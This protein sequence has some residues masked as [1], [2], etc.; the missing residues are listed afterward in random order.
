MHETEFLTNVAV[1]LLAALAGGFLAR[2]MRL[3]VLIGY[4]VAGVFIGPH[5]PGVIASPEIV[6]A[7][8]KLGVA[9]LMFTV[10][11]HFSLDRL[12]SVRRVALLGGGLQIAGTV[13]LG[14]L[15]GLALG[16]GLYGGLF[17]GCAISLSSTAV[18]T[19]L[20]EERGEEGSPHGEA[21]LAVLIAQD[22][23][24]VVMTPLLPALSDVARHGVSAAKALAGAA[25]SGGLLLALILLLAMRVVPALMKRMTGM[26]S[27]ELFLLTGLG[28]CLAAA[29]AAE[30]AGIGL[31]LG[32]FLA[33]LVISET[34]YAHELFAQIRPLRDVF[35]ALFFVS[36]G[37]LLNP[38]FLR[39]HWVAVAAVV[40]AI[41]FGKAL[42]SALAVRAAGR[43]G[44]TAVIA[45]LGLAQIGEFS[46]VLASIGSAR[47]L[48]PGEISGVI[49]SAALISLVLAPFLF[50]AAFPLAA[51]LDAAPALSRFR[52]P[53]VG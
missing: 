29:L 13:A 30:R 36:I 26:G 19:K 12:K 22:L 11:V 18:M 28:I 53:S 45:G 16:W 43:P 37:M 2:A 33:G 20:L 40:A 34:D 47:G 31:E 42:I 1:A 46:F 39:L 41:V 32:A 49:L 21:L 8:A 50:S 23:C 38:S 5:T 24:V 44:R 6:H 35:A 15:L 25:L 27:P 48:I 14:V 9:L 4:L 52:R 3:P 10:G 17:L 51:R 7:V